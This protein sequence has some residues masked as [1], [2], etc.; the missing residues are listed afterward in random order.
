LWT[1]GLAR[2]GYGLLIAVGFLSGLLHLALLQVVRRRLARID[3]P[4]KGAYSVKF[5][6]WSSQLPKV[7]RV[8]FKNRPDHIV[9]WLQLLVRLNAA[10]FVF[11]FVATFCLALKAPS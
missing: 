3:D 9:G 5:I 6:S 11:A 4:A 2:Q 10:L 7:G 8:L 1:N